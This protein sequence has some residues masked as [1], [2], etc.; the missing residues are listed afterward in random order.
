MAR[1]FVGVGSNIMPEA[2]VR[3][4]LCLL[5]RSVRLAGVSTFYLTQA[6]GER[7][8]PACRPAGGPPFYN[9]VVEVE[10]GI[11]P[12][13]LKQ[14]VL[15]R[16]EQ[17]LGR[18]RGADRFAARSIDL[19]LLLYGDLVIAG[20]ELTVPDPEIGRRPFLAIPLAELD[21]D[22][23]LPGASV[24]MRQL[25]ARHAGHDMRPLAEY[26]LLLRKDVTDGS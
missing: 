10:T 7:E 14:S 1:A 11:P 8:Q 12:S 25:A 21:P 22:L 23:V 18:R 4:A 3:W 9:G 6:L 2:N 26:T 19:D 20:E 15:R 17:Q 24:T 16:I 13:E 5:R